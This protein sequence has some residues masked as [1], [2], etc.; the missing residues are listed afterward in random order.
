MCVVQ[1]KAGLKE[2][3]DSEVPFPAPPRTAGKMHGCNMKTAKWRDRPVAMPQPFAKKNGSHP[4]L[5]RKMETPTPGLEPTS[6]GNVT[7]ANLQTPKTR[8][9]REF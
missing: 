5:Q 1:T 8:A 3:S 6:S 2:G 7:L 4:E 9:S